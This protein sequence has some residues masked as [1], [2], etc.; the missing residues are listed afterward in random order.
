MRFS[1]QT[2]YALIFLSILKEASRTPVSVRQVS[3]K[4]GVPYS[5][6]EKIAGKLKR[7]GI[8]RAEKGQAGGYLLIK[9]PATVSMDEV[10]ALFER[11][12]AMACLTAG[13]CFLEKTCPTRRRWE[14]LDKK[15]LKVFRETTLAE[16]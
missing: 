7:A 11:Q 16:I 15:I 9:N 5:F 13:G 12:R 1:K 3:E 6:M 14:I 10:F 4:Y 8:V 2:D